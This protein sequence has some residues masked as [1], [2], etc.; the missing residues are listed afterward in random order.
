MKLGR[1]RSYGTT[2][3]LRTL[4]AL[5]DFRDEDGQDQMSLWKVY[6]DCLVETELEDTR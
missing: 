4:G 2:G 1:V 6:S 3:L 5:E